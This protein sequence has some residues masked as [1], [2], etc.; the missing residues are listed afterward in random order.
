MKE[1]LPIQA[2]KHNLTHLK[3][4]VEYNKTTK[5][6]YL[7]VAPVARDDRFERQIL[8]SPCSARRETITVLKRLNQK[9]IDTQA[10]LAASELHNKTGNTWAFVTRFLNETGLALA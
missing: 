3:I 9:M 5:T 2:N 7:W 8:F 6:V 4:S 1:Y 10:E